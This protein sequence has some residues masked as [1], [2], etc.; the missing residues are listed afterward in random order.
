RRDILHKIAFPIGYGVETSHIL[1]VYAELGLDAF[2]QTDLDQRVHRNQSTSALGKMSFGILQ[3]FLNRLEKFE[4]LDRLP[5]LST[6]YRSFV[7]EGNNYQLTTKKIV[8]VE[9]PPMI[10]IPEYRKKFGIPE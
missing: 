1:D 2:A 8:E 4:M 6:V 10:T 3:S 5:E 7:A 9:R